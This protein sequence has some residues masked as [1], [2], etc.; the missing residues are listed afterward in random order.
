MS[1]RL[2][3][4]QSLAAH[5]RPALAC[6]ALALV[7]ALFPAADRAE[8][9]RGVPVGIYNVNN[10]TMNS[11]EYVYATRF[12]VDDDTTLYRFLSGFN[13]E[14]SDQLGGRKG[15]SGGNAG[16]IR[17]RLVAVKPHGATELSP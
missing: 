15:Y 16:T 9:Y 5:S 3:R 14:G 2:P 7:A 10:Q 8:A 12:V 4:L 17:A 11:S 13:L 6:V 1:D